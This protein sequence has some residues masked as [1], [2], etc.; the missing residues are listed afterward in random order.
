MNTDRLPGRQRT[1]RC[2]RLHGQGPGGHRLHRQILAY[3]IDIVRKPESIGSKQNDICNNLLLPTCLQ[4][5]RV[6][7]TGDESE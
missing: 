4:Q 5:A 1:K 7:C 2:Q 6:R 3:N